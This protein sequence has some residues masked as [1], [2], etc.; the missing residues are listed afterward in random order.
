MGQGKRLLVHGERSLLTRVL[1]NII[2]NAV[3]YSPKGTCIT[4]VLAERQGSD[5]KLLATCAVTDEGPGIAPEHRRIIFERFQRA[6]M[7]LGRKIDGVGLGLSLVHTVITRHKGE[8]ECVSE[9]G[10]GSTFTIVL[11]MFT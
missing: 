8:I 6:P 1:V 4:C 3:K 5:G 7:G 9:P 2:G 10:Q 11:P